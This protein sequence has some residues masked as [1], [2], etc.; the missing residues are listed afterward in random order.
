MSVDTSFQTLSTGST[1]PTPKKKGLFGGLLGG[2]KTYFLIAIGMAILAMFAV[3]SLLGNAAERSTYYI[4]G[5]NVAE[6]T[7]ITPDML[8]AVETSVGTEPINALAPAELVDPETGEPL[9]ALTPL[10]A[11]DVVSTSVVGPL[12]RIASTIPEDYVLASLAVDADA[13]VAG[14]IR[15]GDV[16][17]VY[18]VSDSESGGKATKMVLY[19]VQVTDVVV[20]PKSIA[21]AANDG[22]EGTDLDPGPESNAVRGGIPQVYVLAVSPDDAAKI[23]LIRGMD[24]MLVLSANKV[25]DS[26]DVAT[27][28]TRVFDDIPVD[29]SV[30]GGSPVQAPAPG[31]PATDTATGAEATAGDG[32]APGSVAGTPTD[33]ATAE[34]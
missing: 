27:D 4:L 8:V 9:F 24:V 17:D 13:A 16:V 23:A 30:D 31:G 33:P 2:G 5:V 26:A 15:T 21:Q 19:R 34:N 20:Q 28:L 14:K 3:L 32:A 25:T 18:A 6:R 7:Q 10:K 12:P 22:Q 29:S 1:P 11:G